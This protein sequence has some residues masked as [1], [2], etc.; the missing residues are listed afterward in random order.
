MNESKSYF[1]LIIISLMMMSFVVREQPRP[2]LIKEEKLA[3]KI[4][5]EILVSTY[6]KKMINRRKPL[7][8]EIVRDSIWLVKGT[9]PEGYKGGNPKIEINAFTCEVYLIDY[10]K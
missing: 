2:F 10:G 9:I 3:K 7:T 8:A 1:I 5:K 4:G 6:G